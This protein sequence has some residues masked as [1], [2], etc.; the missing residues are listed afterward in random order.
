MDKYYEVCNMDD[1]QLNA[2]SVQKYD[3]KTVYK[4]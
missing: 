2:F 4:R 3:H 1:S